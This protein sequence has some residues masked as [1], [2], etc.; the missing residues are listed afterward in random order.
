MYYTYIVNKDY[1]IITNPDGIPTD[2]LNVNE[3]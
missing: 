1:D 2:A 3:E